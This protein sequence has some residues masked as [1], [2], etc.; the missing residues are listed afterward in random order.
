M[1][2]KH[3]ILIGVIVLLLVVA[4]YFLNSY[5]NR[6]FTIQNLKYNNIVINNT[7]VKYIDTITHVTLNLLNQYG[8]LIDVYPLSDSM[9]TK[10][11]TDFELK[12]HIVGKKQSYKIYINVNLTR[13]E[14]ISILLHELIHLSQIELGKLRILTNNTVIWNDTVINPN[15]IDYEKRPWEIDCFKQ[16]YEIY[17]LLIQDLYQ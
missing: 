12:S 13:R 16:Q 11:G 6:N 3:L 17:P 15:L 2:N 5:R 8:N 4:L 1:K 14:Y 10:L 9:I 7:N